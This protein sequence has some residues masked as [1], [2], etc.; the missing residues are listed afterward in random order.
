MLTLLTDKVVQSRPRQPTKVSTPAPQ[1]C[2]DELWYFDIQP[3]LMA[4]D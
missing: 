2:Q 1:Y 4:T 3:I